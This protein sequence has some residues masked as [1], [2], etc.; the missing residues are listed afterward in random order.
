MCNAHFNADADLTLHI[1]LIRSG[2]K[3]L[4]DGNNAGSHIAAMKQSS[5]ESSAAPIMGMTATDIAAAPATPRDQVATKERCA[6]EMDG[7]CQGFDSGYDSGNEEQADTISILPHLNMAYGNP[8]EYG[9][10]AAGFAH[11]S[12]SEEEEADWMVDAASIL[13]RR[14]TGYGCALEADGFAAGFEAG[15]DSE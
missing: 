8:L 6:L 4:L 15:Y 5:S 13:P 11:S 2:S 10:F 7:F 9:G 12:D 1:T 14:D 3:G